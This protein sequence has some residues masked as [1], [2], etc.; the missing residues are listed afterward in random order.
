[1]N[2]IKHDCICGFQHF[3]F[4]DLDNLIKYHAYHNTMY[5]VLAYLKTLKLNIE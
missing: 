2:L 4:E 5:E 3:A 1:M